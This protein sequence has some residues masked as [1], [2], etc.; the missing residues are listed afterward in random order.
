MGFELI[1]GIFI[2]IINDLKPKS[3]YDLDD[4]VGFFLAFL[5]LPANEVANYG[6]QCDPLQH[7]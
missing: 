3:E 5:Q 2:G 7:Y 4:S 1:D 6:Y